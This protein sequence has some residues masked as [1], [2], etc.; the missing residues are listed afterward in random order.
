M[1]RSFSKC[2]SWPLSEMLPWNRMAARMQ[3]RDSASA[4]SLVCQPT[5]IMSP[6]PSSSA[7][8]AGKSMPGTP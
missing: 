2:S 4:A 1:V 7:I 8:T 3:N 5:A 6:A